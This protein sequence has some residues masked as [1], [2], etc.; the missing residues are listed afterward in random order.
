MGSHSKVAVA[1]VWTIAVLV[2]LSFVASGIPKINPGVGMIDRFEAWGYSAG[3]ATA[4]GWVEVLGGLLVIFPKSRVWGAGLLSV[5]MIGA[6]VTHVRSGIG[7]P[8]TAIVY[9]VLCITLLGASLRVGRP[10]S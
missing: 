8:A 4:I 5:N 10:T 7:S 2:G 9:L 1:A 3:F 6:I